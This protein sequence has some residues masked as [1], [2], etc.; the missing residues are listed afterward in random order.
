M[1]NTSE[2]TRLQAGMSAARRLYALAAALLLATYLLSGIRVVAPGEGAVVLRF[3]RLAKSNGETTVH[4]AGLLLAW[5]QPI[6]RVVRLPLK[7]E[8]RV[9]IDQFWACTS[10]AHTQTAAEH[11]LLSG[12]HNL[13]R[14]DLAARYRIAQPVEYVTS[15]KDAGGMVTGCV[16]SAVTAIIQ[17]CSIDESLR[18]RRDRSDQSELLA[19]LILTRAQQQLSACGCGL[20]LTAIELK[21]AQPPTEVQ[22]EFEAVQTARI[23]LETTTEETRGESAQTLLEAE[24]EAQQLR[25]E[26]QGALESRI[27]QAHVQA[28][29]FRA[30]L[31]SYLRAPQMTLERLHREAWQQLFA[32]SRRIYFAPDRADA[33]V[34]RIPVEPAEVAR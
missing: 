28:A 10:D 33:S 30:D 5:P 24:A 15:C 14:L 29:H 2:T 9:N 18:Q 22:A 3:G 26:A 13:V 19:D 23:D 12:D 16:K 7:T 20:R 17:S 31:D 1:S 32:Q 4:P 25:Y 8:Q 11:Y 27:A 6:E 21:Q 34:L